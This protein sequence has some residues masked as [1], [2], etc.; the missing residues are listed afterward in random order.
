MTLV[1]ACSK[2]MLGKALPLTGVLLLLLVVAG[3]AAAAPACE[4]A[5]SVADRTVAAGECLRLGPGAT[6]TGA[7]LVDGRLV[8]AGS[9]ESPI[10]VTGLVQL[11]G[12]PSSISHA[13]FRDGGSLEV[14][15]AAQKTSVTLSDLS[16][17]VG[18]G[19]TGA[20]LTDA[21]T[22]D[23]TRLAFSG[24]GTGVLA[25]YGG[26]GSSLSMTDSTFEG[27]GRAIDA[28]FGNL[29]GDRLSLSGNTFRGARE[30]VAGFTSELGVV[31]VRGA[32]SGEGRPSM[33]TLSDN[34]FEDS[35]VGLSLG[36][37][38][39][40]LLS[41][42]DTF[43]ANAA[44]V[45]IA[46][47]GRNAVFDRATFDGNL[48]YDL[49]LP[50]TGDATIKDPV[51]FDA[52]KVYVTEASSV[53]VKSGKKSMEITYD[54]MVENKAAT[55]GAVTGVAVLGF[56][57]SAFGR[58]FLLQFAFVPLYARLSPEQVLNHEKRQEILEYVRQNP[59]VHLR[60]IGHT[61]AIS[62]GTLTYH[63]YRLERE[64]YITF[65][66]EGLFK[67][68]YSTV[69]RMKEAAKLQPMPTALRDL[70]RQ[71]FDTIVANPGSAQSAIA[72]KLGL[73][74]QAL[75]YHIKKLEKAGFITKVPQGRETLVYATQ[76]PP[77]V[78]AAEPVNT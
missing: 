38:N 77:A 52:G 74:R 12:E 69:G 16:F 1:E 23:A 2:A 43:R 65:A 70:E 62:Y 17:S 31:A 53:S 3:Q 39:Y 57:L 4:T 47:E 18:D 6:V 14:L 35:T 36:A 68:Y 49:V 9:A 76:Q 67:R 7:L 32:S 60:R 13:S 66:Q 64:G 61:L 41:T 58:A 78:A 63:L 10:V 51:K 71:I 33:I 55:A 21:W 34:L 30:D 73:S 42:G 54:W 40:R 37:A 56:G 45:L 44:G 24:P 26:K 27:P 20:R 11:R 19:R 50:S 46:A 75:H 28:T 59:G 5:E 8:A 72:A 22:I 25:I 15:G 29:G 48:Q